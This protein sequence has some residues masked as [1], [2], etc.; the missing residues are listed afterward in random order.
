MVTVFGRP[1]QGASEVEKSPRLDLATEFLTVAYDGT[2]S[3]NVSI[4]ITW[5]S[6]GA[7]PCKEKK[8][9]NSSGLHVIEMARVAWHA[10]FQPL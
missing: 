3:P 7:L 10:S 2:C 1:G 4:R 8:L 5:I 9:D 6:L